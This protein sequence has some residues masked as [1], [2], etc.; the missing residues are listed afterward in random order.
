MASLEALLGTD[1]AASP[2]T[3]AI[4][5]AAATSSVGGAFL[6]GYQAALRALVPDLPDGLVA[7][8]ATEEGGAHPRAIA[9]LLTLD[10]EIGRAHV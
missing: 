6:A 9:T 1:G 7:L 10:G 5:G 3:A 4:R 2:L 8:C